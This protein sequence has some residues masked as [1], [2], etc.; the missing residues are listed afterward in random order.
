MKTQ[1]WS[2][3]VCEKPL[4][5]IK[6]NLTDEYALHACRTRCNKREDCRAFE[7]SRNMYDI[8]DNGCLLRHCQLPV[9]MPNVTKAIWNNDTTRSR[10][11]VRYWGYIKRKYNVTEFV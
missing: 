3:A 4:L 7:F 10:P 11:D 8:V 2:D 1:T 6:D 5:T 9:P